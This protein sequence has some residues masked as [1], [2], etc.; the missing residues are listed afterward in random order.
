[1]DMVGIVG[2]RIL[3][4]PP[5]DTHVLFMGILQSAKKRE[6]LGFLG[7]LYLTTRISHQRDLVLRVIKDLIRNFILEEKNQEDVGRFLNRYELRGLK[8]ELEKFI[9]DTKSRVSTR[10]ILSFRKRVQNSPR[11]RKLLTRRS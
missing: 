8:P 11:L 4:D 9:S 1:M 5:K 3:Y 10:I 6:D 2:G 7:T